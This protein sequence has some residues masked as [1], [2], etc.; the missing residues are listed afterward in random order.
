MFVEGTQNRLPC[1]TFQTRKPQNQ[2]RAAAQLIR[3]RYCYSSGSYR[4]GSAPMDIYQRWSLPVGATC[5]CAASSST[6]ARLQKYSDNLGEPSSKHRIEQSPVVSRLFVTLLGYPTTCTHGHVSHACTISL[7][8][9]MAGG[10]SEPGC[11]ASPWLVACCVTKHHRQQ[12]HE[13]YVRLHVQKH[14]HGEK[15][16]QFHQE[17]TSELSALHHSGLTSQSKESS[18]V[19]QRRADEIPA[20]CG[21]SADR[22][23]YKRII[24]GKEAHFAQFP[25]Q[26][27]IRIAA[28]Q[29]GGV[30]VSQQYVATAAHCIIRARLSEIVVYLGELDTQDTGQVLELA[31]AEHH[32]VRRKVV[33]PL[34]RFKVTQPDRYD[35]ALLQLSIA[36]G[37]MFH[38]SPVCLPQPGIRLQ[39]RS[40]VV[41]GWGK[42]KPSTELTGT[43]VLRSATVPILD[44]GECVKWHGTRQINV[45]LHEDMVC[46]GHAD[47]SQDACLGDSGGPL[48]VLERGHWTLVGITSAGF[49]CGEPRQPG[50]YHNV[51]LTADWI[52]NTIE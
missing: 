13:Q 42:V 12:P 36:A 45:D 32:R 2:R 51:A 52:R 1:D 6:R 47:G 5:S 46:A 24:G 33:H 22:V 29:C 25:W 17:F 48:I 28:Y 19:L 41:A 35:L 9:W 49:G 38:I 10:R 31:P 16:Q 7:A 4:H 11:G 34:F 14:Q 30:L 39:G 43:N 23:L 3:T 50:I 8:C 20:R 21:V 37:R 26:A 40:G 18:T 27:H 44:S 15:Q